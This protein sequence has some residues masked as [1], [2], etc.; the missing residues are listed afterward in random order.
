[1]ACGCNGGGDVELW[2]VIYADNTVSGPMTKLEAD[3]ASHRAG[4][5]WIRKVERAPVS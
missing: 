1:M 4:G 2:E 3:A 5:S